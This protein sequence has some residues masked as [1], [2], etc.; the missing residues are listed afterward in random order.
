MDDDM[1][2]NARFKSLN[3]AKITHAIQGKQKVCGDLT[4]VLKDGCFVCEPA[5]FV[6]VRSKLGFPR[7]KPTILT[8]SPCL[9]TV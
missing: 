2:Q 6:V 5:T 7:E 9:I 4:K 3:H 1:Q 8:N